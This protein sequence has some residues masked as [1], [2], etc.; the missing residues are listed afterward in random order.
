MAESAMDG[1][2]R[3]RKWRA[4]PSSCG[5]GIVLQSGASMV[6]MLIRRSLWRIAYRVKRCRGPIAADV[7]RQHR[8]RKARPPEGDDADDGKPGL[9]RRDDP[10][11]VVSF[12]ATFRVLLASATGR[13][14]PRLVAHDR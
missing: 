8:Q 10:L 13:G 3:P 4:A 6:L 14:L 7:K 12:A 1:S 9:E 5:A 2:V 11:V